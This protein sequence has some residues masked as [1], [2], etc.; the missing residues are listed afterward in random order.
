MI[1]VLKYEISNVLMCT[2]FIGE[3]GCTFVRINKKN[4]SEITNMMFHSCSFSYL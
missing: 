3:N 4:T 2:E 1:Y